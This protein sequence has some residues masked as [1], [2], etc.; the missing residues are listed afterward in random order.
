[1]GVDAPR[2]RAGNSGSRV[3]CLAGACGARMISLT[4]LDGTTISIPAPGKKSPVQARCRAEPTPRSIQRSA[5]PRGTLVSAPAR[6]SSHGVERGARILGTEPRWEAMFLRTAVDSPAQGG[7]SRTGSSWRSFA[8]SEW[9]TG[10]EV[11]ARSP[12]RPQRGD[13]FPSLVDPG[14]AQDRIGV[15][16]PPRGRS[17]ANAGRRHRV[18]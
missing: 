14:F 9:V 17:M 3:S 8:R 6:G 15:L 12:F 4:L 13:R 2:V 11:S 5:D 10:S 16:A 7:S 1:V 18:F